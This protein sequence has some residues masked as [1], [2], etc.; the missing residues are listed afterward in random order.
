MHHAQSLFSHPFLHRG[1]RLIADRRG[2]ALR[3]AFFSCFATL[4]GLLQPWISKILVDEG[5]LRGNLKV[6][7]GSAV[8]MLFAPLFGLAIET[9]TR[10]DY[11][12]L[13]SHVLFGLREN[14]FEHLQRLSPAYYSKV[15][16]GDLIARFDGD[17]AE[18]QRF[19]VDG[20]L[21]LFNGVFSLVTATLMMMYMDLT[22]SMIVLLSVFPTAIWHAIRNR[23]SQEE[24]TRELR[25]HSTR[26]SAY[27]LDSLRALKAI[28][29]SNGESARLVGLREQHDAYFRALK[30]SH[31]AGFSVSTGQRISTLVGSVLIFGGGGYLLA[32][33]RISVGTLIAFVAF[34][35]RIG[36]SIQTLSGLIGGWQRANVSIERLTDI[37]DAPICTTP[38]IC[39]PM[40]ADLRGELAVDGIDFSYTIEY[41]VFRNAN[42]HIPAGSRVLLNGPS[43]SGKSTFTDLLLGHLKVDAGVI[44]IDGINIA[45]IDLKLLRS[46]VA[47]VDQEPAF[48]PGS[49]AD[50]LRLAAPAATIQELEAALNSVGLKAEGLSLDNLLGAIGPSL[51]RGQRL[52]L[53]LARA[54]LQKPSLLVLDETTSALDPVV[55]TMILDLVDRQF[56]GRTRIIISHRPHRER[57]WDIVCRLYNGR[58][59]ESDRQDVSYVD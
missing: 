37:L 41:P 5:A 55:E 43:G 57:T 22:M 3:V 48:L 10:F 11:L 46:K 13:S 19:L 15:G 14:L 42:L 56:D 47:V 25:R 40:P 32:Q 58:F 21:A 6:L 28:Q 39:Q 53:A 16:F 31:E 52:R 33:E 24:V 35:S 27:F 7:V 2:L 20:P 59:S 12:R 29:S 45:A 49:I 8:A 1:G 38:D 34:A 26:L 23:R 54:L 4:F 51:S 18:I 36:G 30:A 50:N 9:L 44:R 17:I